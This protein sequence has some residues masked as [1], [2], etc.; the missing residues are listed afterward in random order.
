MLSPKYSNCRNLLNDIADFLQNSGIIERIAHNSNCIIELHDWKRFRVDMPFY[1]P[2]HV[3]I[4]ANPNLG[5]KD[6]LRRAKEEI[7]N[8]LVDFIHKGILIS[9]VFIQDIIP[10]TDLISSPAI[11]TL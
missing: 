11:Y 1:D 5:A 9:I 4:E 3:R 7:E 2:T 10:L 6:N 8:V